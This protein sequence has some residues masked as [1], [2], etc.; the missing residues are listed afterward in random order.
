MNYKELK[1][2]RKVYESQKEERDYKKVLD[3][4]EKCFDE[5]IKGSNVFEVSVDE[6]IL[7]QILDS[8]EVEYDINI[9]PGPWYSEMYLNIK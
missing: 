4:V 1:E 2:A 6:N 8:K 3:F 9:E 5:Y 7:R